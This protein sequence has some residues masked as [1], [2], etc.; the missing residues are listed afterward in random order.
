MK[1]LHIS[2]KLPLLHKNTGGAEKAA[3]NII[4]LLK[5]SKE[6]DILV[7][8]TFY[9]GEELTGHYVIRTTPGIGIIKNRIFNFDALSYFS[10]LGIFRRLKPKVIHFHKFNMIS[11]SALLAAK[12]LKIKT[13]LSIYDYWYFSSTIFLLKGMKKGFFLRRAVFNFFLKKIDRFVVLSEDSA[14][15]LEYYGINKAKIKVIRQVMDLPKENHH[16]EHFEDGLLVF[17]GWLVPYKGAEVAIRALKEILKSYPLARLEV[18]GMQADKHYRDKLFDLTFKLDI[19]DKVKFFGRLG[20][21]EFVKKI[22]Q[23]NVLIVPEAWPNMSPVIIAEAMAHAKAIVASRIGGIP[24]FIQDGESGYLAEPGEAKEFADKVLKL[25]QDK[26][27]AIQFG[28]NARTR[29]K[30]LF[31]KDKIQK[32]LNG[33]YQKI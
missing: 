28:E 33:L 20:R 9:K 8:T 29:A 18:L 1:I 23:A 4:W 30:E 3:N 31:N 2:D 22:K 26:D 7:A 5:N 14:R 17:A 21:D 27:K 11:F 10:A 32:E 19:K 13:V 16:P 12:A 15:V 25:F 24:E 6:H